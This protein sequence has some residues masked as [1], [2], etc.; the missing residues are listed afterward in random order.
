MSGISEK[1][2]HGKSGTSLAMEALVLVGFLVLGIHNY[3][4]FHGLVEIFGV[5]IS[6]SIFLIAWNSRRIVQNSYLLL[7]G[8]AF[9]SVGIVDILHTLSYKGMGMFP[10]SGA[11]HAT[12]LWLTARFLQS[13]S[14][15]VAPLFIGRK[16]K[17]EYILAGYLAATILLLLSIFTFPVFPVSYIEGDG[18]TRFKIVSEEIIALSLVVAIGFHARKRQAFD[19]EVLQLIIASLAVAVLSELVFTLYTGVYDYFN[20]AGHLLKVVSFYLLYKAFIFTALAKPYHILFRELKE[21]EQRL[22]A[23][24][25]RARRYFDI[26]GVIL[27]IIGAD[28]R[29][30]LINREG[31]RIL[32]L[33]EE[34]IVGRNW[35]DSFLPSNIREDLRVHF[36]RMVHSG[37]RHETPL[38]GLE[39]PIVT[40]SGEKRLIRWNNTI[41]RDEYGEITGTLSSGEDITERRRAEELERYRELFENV[42]DS[43]FIVSRGERFL[44]ANDRTLEMTGYSREELLGK[45]V[46]EVVPLERIPLVEITERKIR[47]EGR[48][49]F[50]FD[51]RNKE[52]KVVPLYITCKATDFHGEPAYLCVA[53]DITN[54]KMLQEELIRSERL[55]AT[56]RATASI[57]HEIKN[58]LSVIG[59]FARAIRKRPED[60][61]RVTRNAS[62]IADEIDRLEAL[63]SEMLDFSRPK[64]PR[65]E[66]ADLVGLLSDTLDLLRKDADARK[67]HIETEFPG[68]PLEADL[69]PSRMKQVFLNLTQN[70][71]NA[72]PEGG[73]IK[74]SATINDRWAT[75][76]IADTGRG[77]PAEHLER[78]FEPF[79][80]THGRGTGLGLAISQRIIESH[81]GS[82][83]L[84]SEEGKGTTVHV[85]LPR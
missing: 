67:V 30:R 77:I 70:A 10:D 83:T 74:V 66:R 6:V 37:E 19:P 17:E 84:A 36:R 72:M 14:L 29:V 20:M 79:F 49:Q 2:L 1:M 55:A 12:Q 42:D 57:V 78:V 60:T 25:D 18:L 34:E 33:P 69:D 85:Q 50:E 68:Q 26:A 15:L 35:F 3:L 32:G 64:P 80:T 45:Q 63:V 56:G 11:N 76:D 43:V 53:R 46:R 75:V 31:V 4:L 9:L 61:E 21:S 58:P 38:P 65:K 8:I 7:L 41:L 16:V 52:G 54:L 51:F 44:E 73:I 13:A 28:E 39:N 5:I 62:I 27:V 47:R 82:I 24:R 22:K 40:G 23:E 59:G 48:T 71:I 81:G